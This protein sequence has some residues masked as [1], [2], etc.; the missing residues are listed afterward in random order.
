MDLED[1]PRLRTRRLE[2]VA[3]TAEL[4]RAASDGNEPLAR[5]L[6]VDVP[7]SWPPPA[8]AARQS[9]YARA[10]EA[11]VTLA[12]WSFWFVVE[13]TPRVLVGAIGFRGRPAAD[14][15]VEIGYAMLDKY[16][17]RGFATE[18]MG[19]LID[20][21]F[22]HDEVR[23]VRAHTSPAELPSIRVLENNGLRRA[24]EGAEPGTICFEL[25]RP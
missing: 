19:A 18:A 13:A 2:L 22:S 17:R 24:G 10:L 1:V 8:H 6:D 3:A 20:W 4:A 15:T 12:G 25:A 16:Q 23:R 9:G 5:A 14:G 21:A 11:D 7:E